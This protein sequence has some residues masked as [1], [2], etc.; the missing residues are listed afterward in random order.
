MEEFVTVALQEAR[1][2]APE[3]PEEFWDWLKA[4][5]KRLKHAMSIGFP[6]P[7][8]FLRNLYRLKN[9]WA[10]QLAEHPQL[11]QYAFS[12]A[13]VHQHRQGSMVRLWEKGDDDLTG[14]EA[15]AAM[16]ELEVEARYMSTLSQ[17]A[18]DH[19]E[20]LRFPLKRDRGP[21]AFE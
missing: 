10:D 17:C 8:G 12:Y 19:V 6:S 16:P 1:T 5:D 13:F 9:L 18:M 20:E 21:S 15:L 14:F 4:S 7:S 11:E 3:L 2:Y